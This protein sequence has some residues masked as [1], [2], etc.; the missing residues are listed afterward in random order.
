MENILF[1]FF[2][3]DIYRLVTIS[4]SISKISKT[5][6]SIKSILRNLFFLHYYMNK[7][8]LQKIDLFKKSIKCLKSWTWWTL[9]QFILDN[10][11]GKK[12]EFFTSCSVVTTEVTY[13]IVMYIPAFTLKRVIF[14]SLFLLSSTINLQLAERTMKGNRRFLFRHMDTTTNKL[15]L[16]NI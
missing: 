9:F 11:V 4:I 6:G 15:Q 16:K 5:I 7:L 8:N 10:I 13:M 1:Y 2:W 3:H 14:I 12:N